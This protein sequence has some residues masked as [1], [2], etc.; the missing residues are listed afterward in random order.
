M[1]KTKYTVELPFQ[2]TLSVEVYANSKEEALRIGEREI[3]S[4]SLEDVINN[5][6]WGDYD[7]YK[8]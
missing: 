2:G 7:V 6:E 3:E 8:D 1:G 5:A 4:M